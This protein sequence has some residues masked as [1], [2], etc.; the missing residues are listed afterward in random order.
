MLTFSQLGHARRGLSGASFGLRVYRVCAGADR[1]TVTQNH[2]VQEKQMVDPTRH[3]EVHTY[4]QLQTYVHIHTHPPTDI[5]ANM[6]EHLGY[7]Q[8]ELASGHR[9]CETQT[10]NT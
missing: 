2:V 3:A 8:A 7:F 5:H 1:D 6:N 4:V 10:S 9:G